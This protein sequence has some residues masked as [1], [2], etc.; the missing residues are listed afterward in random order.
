VSGT[1]YAIFFENGSWQLRA[2][3]V[4][5]IHCP[6]N[7]ETRYLIAARELALMKLTAFVVNTARRAVMPTSRISMQVTLGFTI[8]LR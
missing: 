6:L 2:A 8:C 3:Y 1:K 7:G 4:L 5:S